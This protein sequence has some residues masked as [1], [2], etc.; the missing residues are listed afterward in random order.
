M[1]VA[2]V[3]GFL[4]ARRVIWIDDYFNDSPRRLASMLIEKVEVTRECDLPGVLAIVG[5]NGEPQEGMEDELE[6]HLTDLSAEGR[7]TVK[8]SFFEALRRAGLAGKELGAPAVE[9]V[10]DLLRIAADDRWPFERAREEIGPLCAGGDDTVSYVVD[11]NDALGSPTEG[12]DIL[13]RLAEAGSRGTAFIL[14]HDTETAEEAGKEVELRGLIREQAPTLDVPVCVIAKERLFGDPTGSGTEDALKVAIKR[15]GLQRSVHEVVWKARDRIASAFQEAA[16]ALLGIAPE[17]LENHVVERAFREGS[18]EL[19]VVERALTAHL[20]RSLREL[21]GTDA[22]VRQGAERMRSLR[23][24]KLKPSYAAPD[25]R[26]ADFRRA[27]VWESDVLI[28]TAL[29]PL[30]CGDVFEMDPYEIAKD[31]KRRRFLLLGQPCDIALRPTERRQQETGIFI[32]LE[33]LTEKRRKALAS[34]AGPLRNSPKAP[35]LPFLLDGIQYACDFRTA[36]SARLAVLDLASF[37][38]DGR[39]R[40]DMGHAADPGLLP[41]QA[42]VYKERTTAAD[43]ALAAGPPAKA[44]KG[45]PAIISV[46]PALQLTFAVD[47]DFKPVFRGIL[48]GN[49]AA[50]EEAKIPALPQRMTWQLRRCGRIRMP[51]ASALLDDYVSVMSRQAFDLDYMTGGSDEEEPSDGTLMAGLGI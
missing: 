42:R 14:T 16:T 48:K 5:K 37:R 43:Q 31:A 50:S 46:P 26:L 21:F 34:G 35:P 8:A 40:V 12:V 11:L 44:A 4:G 18:S 39:V 15:A 17:Q 28:N 25:E 2:D 38:H 22:V 23:N 30:A 27:E 32:F 10:C 19:H 47:N 29:A 33:D 49:S 3:L 41:G 20:S 7:L 51:Y 36:T 13:L 6:Q 24:V 9:R 45:A 1:S